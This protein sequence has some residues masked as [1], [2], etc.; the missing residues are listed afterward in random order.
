MRQAVEL[1][2]WVQH[3]SERAVIEECD[4]I[5][6]VA[7]DLDDALAAAVSTKDP[8]SHSTCEQ[9][10]RLIR[11]LESLPYTGQLYARE[12]GWN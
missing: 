2:R 8:P 1:Q 3:L 12:F 5:H 6:S 9:I 4:S 11:S 7:S 10:A